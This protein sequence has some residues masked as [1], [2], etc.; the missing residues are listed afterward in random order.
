[1]IWYAVGK[2]GAAH[3]R[4]GLGRDQR[5]VALVLA[6][7]GRDILAVDDAGDALH[8]HRHE[9]AHRCSPS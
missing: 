6:F 7:T 5:A 1:M 3:R 2:S 9:Y 4:V 8:V